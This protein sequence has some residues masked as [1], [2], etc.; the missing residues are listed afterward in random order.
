ME[1]INK[2]SFFSLNKKYYSKK[3]FRVIKL[4]T[5]TITVAI[6]FI[7]IALIWNISTPI[8]IIIRVKIRPIILKTI[9]NIKLRLGSFFLLQVKYIVIIKLC[10]L[11]SLTLCKKNKFESRKSTRNPAS[12]FRSNPRHPK[13]QSPSPLKN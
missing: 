1:H 10:Q 6:I 13:R 4:N 3:I 5:I 7:N 8:L 9:N 12:L 11:F 2:I